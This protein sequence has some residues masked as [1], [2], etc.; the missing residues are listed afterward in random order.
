MMPLLMTTVMTLVPPQERGKMMGNISIVMSVAPAIGPVFAGLD[1]RLSRLAL[2]SSSS[3]C[4][5]RSARSALGYA[6][7]AQRHDAALRPARRP[8]GDPV[9]DRLRRHRLWPLGLRRRSRLPGRSIRWIP[10]VVGAWRWCVFV[11]RQLQLQKKDEAL[12]D[13]RTLKVGELHHLDG[14]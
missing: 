3:C 2:A 1:P 6:H 7:D 10:L 4:R 12:L 14:R 13:L 5:S 8:L 11:W 9:G